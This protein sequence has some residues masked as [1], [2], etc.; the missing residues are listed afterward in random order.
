MTQA[1]EIS[2][3]HAADP[4]STSYTFLFVAFVVG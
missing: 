1:S 3:V 4:T 2:Q